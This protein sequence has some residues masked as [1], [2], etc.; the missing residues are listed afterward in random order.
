MLN[1]NFFEN[2]IFFTDKLL[3]EGSNIF[4]LVKMSQGG[5]WKDCYAAVEK[6]DFSLV[7]YYVKMG[8]PLN[9]QH[10]EIM[11][12]LLIESIRQENY[13]IAKFLLENGADPSEEEDFGDDSPLS[14]AESKKNKKLVELIKSYLKK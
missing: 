10:P 5:Y 9:F 13:E 11:T 14:A 2:H 6:N 1:K 4:Q 8:V 3:I 12:T 7:Q